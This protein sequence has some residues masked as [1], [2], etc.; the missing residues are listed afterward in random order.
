MI[1][2]RLQ[3]LIGR[4]KNAVGNPLQLIGQNSHAPRRIDARFVGKITVCR[5]QHD[6]TNVIPIDQFGNVALEAGVSA[7]KRDDKELPHPIERGHFGQECF[8]LR[9]ERRNDRSC[10]SLCD[11]D[12]GG[13]RQG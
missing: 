12:V 2:H 9:I 3:R 7:I 13:R 4:Q 5:A 6:T 11:R 1:G 8:H 10:G